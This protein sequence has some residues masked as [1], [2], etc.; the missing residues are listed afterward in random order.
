MKTQSPYLD[1]FSCLLA[2]ALPVS[3]QDNPPSNNSQAA[4]TQRGIGA[5]KARNPLADKVSF[6]IDNAFSFN[7]GSLRGTAYE[8]DASLVAPSSLGNDWLILHRPTLPIMHDPESIPGQGG[9]FGLGD[10]TYQAL[11]TRNRDSR[12][13]WG[14]GPALVF[15]TATSSR[16]GSGK[17]SAG[18]AAGIVSQPGHWTFGVLGFNTWSF[19]GDSARQSI[20]QLSLEPF[21]SYD[22]KDGWFVS[23]QPGISADW[24]APRGERWTVPM[25]GGGGKGFTRDG[26]SV[27]LTVFGYYNI[28]HPPGSSP[29]QLS[30]GLEFLFGK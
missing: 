9:K 22:L 17:W 30:M 29:W 28:E 25:G 5:R 1:L 14:V 15:P 26:K 23:C 19:A 2:C 27:F 24:T 13:I 8:L 7:T 11:V 4:S 12:I 18:P 20:N 16:L 6:A 3:A 10:L 21:V